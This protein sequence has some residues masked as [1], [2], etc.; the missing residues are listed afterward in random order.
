[1]WTRLP[2]NPSPY[3]DDWEDQPAHDSP[4]HKWGLGL[5]LPLALVAY[6]VWVYA[7]GVATLREGHGSA[8]TL[9]GPNAT[10]WAV[11]AASV[12]LFLHCHY[13]WG[14]IYDQVWFAVLGKIAAAGAF[15]VAVFYVLVRVGVLGINR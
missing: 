11:A 4:F 9:R 15:C 2:H 10:A 1:M 6:G 5:L 14:A 13:F 8:I 7:T 3:D 12:G